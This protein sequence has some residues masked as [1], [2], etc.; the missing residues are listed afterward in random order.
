MHLT[1]FHRLPILCTLFIGLKRTRTLSC[2]P[3]YRS[4][5]AVCGEPREKRSARFM[6][7]QHGTRVR[8]GQR[9]L[10]AYACGEHTR[11][12]VLVRGLLPEESSHATSLSPL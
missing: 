2:W 12:T 6:V 9:H 7:S 5:G 3:E 8:R 11:T 1:R 10:P 4:G